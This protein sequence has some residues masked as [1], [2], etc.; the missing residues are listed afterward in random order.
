ML[1]KMAVT[2]WNGK[3]PF[4]TVVELLNPD[5][6]KRKD[7]TREI[8]E[9]CNSQNMIK[10]PDALKFM[11]L[12]ISDRSAVWAHLPEYDFKSGK[13][14]IYLRD[15]DTVLEYLWVEK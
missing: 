12:A 11:C 3:Y 4:S 9:R 7:V 13:W 1:T 5:V 6:L 15:E 2:D 8:F 14:M 10:V